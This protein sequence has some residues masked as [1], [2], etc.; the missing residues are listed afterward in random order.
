MADSPP[1]PRSTD[2][3]NEAGGDTVFVALFPTGSETAA[4][5]ASCVTLGLDVSQVSVICSDER[6]LELIPSAMHH[7]T[8]GEAEDEAVGTGGVVAASAG[9]A[10]TAGALLS[11]AGLPL[12]ALGA[13]GAVAMSG[14]FTAM[15]LT[16]GLDDAAADFYDREVADGKV[17][18]AIDAVTEAIVGKLVEHGA[19]TFELPAE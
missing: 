7:P 4:A 11:A 12:A 1:P 6:E 5:L 18:V 3:P 9:V 17:L 10:I 16:R 14:P 13:V 8:V 15:M 19:T 2:P